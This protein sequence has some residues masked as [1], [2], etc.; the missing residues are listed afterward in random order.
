[1]QKHP[2]SN[3]EHST[4]SGCATAE[5][6]TNG[7]SPRHLAASPGQTRSGRIGGG[8]TVCRAVV[9]ILF[10]SGVFAFA[11]SNG[12]PKPDEYAKFS[13][14][15]TD[16]NI[17]DPNRQ[18]H[19]YTSTYRPRTRTRTRTSGT[20]GIQLVGTMSYEK[21]WFAFFNASSDDNKKALYA[22]EKIAGY[23]VKEILPDWVRLES[24]DQK[25]QLDLKVGDGLQQE[26]GKWVLVHAGEMPAVTSSAAT[27]SSSSSSSGENSTPAAPAPATEQND[28][29]KR[30]M[31]LREKE[32]Q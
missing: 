7:G 30:L 15:V 32:N 10:A 29:L 2:T 20:P 8:L 17:F 21:G 26:N 22:G 31:Q 27:G 9:C 25:E 13:A 5:P 18:P 6:A 1:M 14:F 23:V 12:V 19:S 24:A 11:Q 3:V 4:S 28:V 16:R